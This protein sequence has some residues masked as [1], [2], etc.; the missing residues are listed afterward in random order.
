MH[1]SR[2]GPCKPRGLPLLS[3]HVSTLIVL[4]SPIPP[5][6]L[7]DGISVKTLSLRCL[8]AQMALVGQEPVMFR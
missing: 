3:N 1:C 5:Q 7:V 2:L 4:P 6:V 8:R